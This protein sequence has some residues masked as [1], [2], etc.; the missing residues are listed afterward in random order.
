MVILFDLKSTA[1]TNTVLVDEKLNKYLMKKSKI[2]TPTI[3]F[4][5]KLM[6]SKFFFVRSCII[7]PSPIPK[8]KIIKTNVT[9]YRKKGF[10][11]PVYIITG[12]ELM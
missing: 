9:V 8:Q 11:S 10:F 6:I 1:S 5:H 12:A 7:I 4:H 3:H 2:F